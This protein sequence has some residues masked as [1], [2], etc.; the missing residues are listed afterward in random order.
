MT[1]NTLDQEQFDLL[2]LEVSEMGE[3]ELHLLRSLSTVADGAAAIVILDDPSAELVIR[4]SQLQVAPCIAK[5]VDHDEL[6]ETIQSGLQRAQLYRTIVQMRHRVEQWHNDLGD[7]Q[8]AA[9][10]DSANAGP[11]SVDTFVDILCHNVAGALA[12]LRQTVRMLSDNGQHMDVCRLHA[13]PRLRLLLDG[14]QDSI[15]VLEGTKRSFKS[16]D[17]GNLRSRLSRLVEQ[18]EDVSQS[19]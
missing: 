16:K 12:C 15:S 11:V 19:D 2:I 14:M 5:P 8:A 9:D 1:E 7:L 10:V 3:A 4:I 17:L 18:I 13:C 6:R